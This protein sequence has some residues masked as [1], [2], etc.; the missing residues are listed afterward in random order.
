MAGLSY[1]T[2][3]QSIGMIT[4]RNT[5]LMTALLEE[6]LWSGTDFKHSCP[7]DNLFATVGLRIG[8]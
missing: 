8:A 7:T 5:E 1:V 6:G 2:I 3:P 4:K